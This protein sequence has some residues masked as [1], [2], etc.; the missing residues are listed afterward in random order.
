MDF[1]KL[2]QDEFTPEW[3]KSIIH[4]LSP[5][6]YLADILVI[7]SSFAV[8]ALISLMLYLL[9]RRILNRFYSRHCELNPALQACIREMAF[10]FV[11]CL[12]LVLVI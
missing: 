6:P 7:V 9:L 8:G 5:Y 3:V 4:D 10:S 12:P 1:S 11:G 2:I